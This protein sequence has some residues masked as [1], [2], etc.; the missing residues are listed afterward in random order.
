ML[1]D[2]IAEAAAL[3]GADAGAEADG[4]ASDEDGEVVAG[5]ASLGVG[6]HAAIT[7]ATMRT[8]NGLDIRT[9]SLPPSSAAPNRP[10]IQP[11]SKMEPSGEGCWLLTRDGR[12]RRGVARVVDCTGPTEL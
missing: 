5:G 10:R 6:S 9:T 4:P 7:T 8:A 11:C 1:G 12:L 3:A 2:A